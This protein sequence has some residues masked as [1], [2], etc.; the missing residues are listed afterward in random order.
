MSPEALHAQIDEQIDQ[1]GACLAAIDPDPNR[2]DWGSLRRELD[3]VAERCVWALEHAESL[4]VETDEV[5]ELRFQLVDR[6]AQGAA[7]LAAGHRASEASALLER[8]AELAVEAPYESLYRAARDNPLA[9]VRL[10]HARWLCANDR[11]D[12]GRKVASQLDGAEVIFSEFARPVLSA[13]ERVKHLPFIVNVFGVGLALYGR[14][15]VWHDHSYE[16]VRCVCVAW[17][18]LVPVDAYRVRVQSRDTLEVLGRV[19]L[20]QPAK[21]WRWSMLALVTVL[22]LLLVIRRSVV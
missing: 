2:T 8:C 19:P 4:V 11:A 3:D 18:P 1:L 13:P 15:N 14:R 5:H 6:A 16:A 10:Q 22:A 12:E 20:G 21:V 17:V 7:L 9:Y